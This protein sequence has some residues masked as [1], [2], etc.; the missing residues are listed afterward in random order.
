MSA[1]D[2]FLEI[3]LP[4]LIPLAL[5]G[6]GGAD[7]R[8]HSLVVVLGAFGG[9]YEHSGYDLALAFQASLQSKQSGAHWKILASLLCELVGNRA[10]SEHHSRA[11]VSFSDGFGSPGICDTV[12]GTRWDLVPRH[13]DEVGRE[14][15]PQSEQLTDM[16]AIHA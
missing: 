15:R 9:I 2:F 7:M 6:G 14:W 12:F 5:I 1:P 13:H 3:V 4:Y 8:F 10:H 11:I 16:E